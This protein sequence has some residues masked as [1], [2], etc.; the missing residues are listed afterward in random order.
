MEIEICACCGKPKRP[1]APATPL[2]QAWAGHRYGLQCTKPALEP[3]IVAQVPYSGRPIDSITQHGA[4]ALN[5]EAGRIGQDVDTRRP[6]GSNPQSAFPHNDD[7]WLPHIEASGHVGKRW[8]AN[9]C[10]QHTPHCR[11]LGTRQVRNGSGPASGPTAHKIGGNGGI[12][13]APEGHRETVPYYASPEGTEIVPAWECADGC[14]VAALDGQ[15]G[16][17]PTSGRQGESGHGHASGMFGIGSIRQQTYPDAGPASRFFYV[18]DW[19]L[20][21]AEQLA[22]ADPV[23]YEAKASQAERAAGLS[24]RN[25]HNTVKPIALTKWLATLLLPPPAYAPRRLLIPFAGSGSEGIGA[26]LAGWEESVMIE[27]D[28]AYCAIAEK[29]LEWWRTQDQPSLW[30]GAAL[31]TTRP[32]GPTQTDTTL[33]LFPLDGREPRP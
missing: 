9:F 28:A 8:P 2:A 22:Q 32:P 14:P 30:P 33:P 1:K 17:R 7:T 20:E 21:V 23:R 12:F 16:E 31:E 11:P 24:Q 19:A 25:S 13:V 10:V 26:L 4:G 3:I 6:Q 18:A 29:R 5:I 15:A 27:Q